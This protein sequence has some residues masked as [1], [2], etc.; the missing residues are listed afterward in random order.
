MR[1]SVIRHRLERNFS[2][3]PC[4]N[5]PQA[6]S[7]SVFHFPLLL[8]PPSMCDDSQ[9]N[10]IFAVSEKITPKRHNFFVQIYLKSV[11]VSAVEK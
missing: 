4:A 9:M 10:L 3:N 8:F 7:E 2:L 11:F 1:A 6:Q 5:N